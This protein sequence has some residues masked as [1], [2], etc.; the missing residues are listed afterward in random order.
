MHHVI[1]RG[2]E[3]KAVFRD[4]RD[5]EEYLHRLDTCRKRFGL[6]VYAYC[7]M[8]NHVH[9]AVEEGAGRLSKA[10]HLLQFSYTQWF[11]RRWGRVGHLF[12]GRFKS[13]LVDRDEYLHA[14]LR[15]I[16][17][18]PVKAGIVG[19]PHQY[20]WSSDRFFRR[21]RSP[22]WLDLD[23]VLAM[24]GPTRSEAIARYRQLMDGPA[25]PAYEQVS[26]IGGSVKGGEAF[27][28]QVL[29]E[30][31]PL[32]RPRTDWTP[33]KIGRSVASFY[34]LTWAEMRSPERRQDA[35]AA[36]IGAALLGRSRFGI[37]VAEFA[38]LFRREQSTLVRGVLRLERRAIA[39]PKIR[40]RL[41]Q[42]E[43][44]CF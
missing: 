23:R 41:R 2:N 9:L 12:Q 19:R 36:R 7:L 3:R 34:N 21:G 1:A 15:Y 39:D 43:V 6:A 17:S 20:P 35:S 29:G 38:R 32:L 8:T 24:L 10:M 27:A 5:R 22:S 37:P 16:H 14:L 25:G 30:P 28:R 31:P 42:V 13:F 4:D 26:A 11:N 18:N 44:R 33:E 40:E